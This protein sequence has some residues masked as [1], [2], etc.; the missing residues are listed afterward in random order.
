MA[1]PKWEYIETEDGSGLNR[2]RVPG[3]WLVKVCEYVYQASLVMAGQG[4]PFGYDW[5]TSMTFLPDPE[6]SWEV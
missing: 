3:G 2:M 4:E 6:H 1:K 5:R